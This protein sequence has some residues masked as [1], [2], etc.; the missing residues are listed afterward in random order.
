M[1]VVHLSHTDGG[2][3]AGRAAYRIHTSL[4][5]KG[6][7]SALLVSEKRTLDPTV[8]CVSKTAPGR[9]F[10]HVFEY[11]EARVARRL[12]RDSSVF[13]SPAR[14]AH[15]NPTR[16]REVRQ[17]DIVAT[18]WTNG[19]FMRP[20]GLAGLRQPIVWRLSDTW[21]FTGGC[22]YPGHCKGFEEHCGGCPQLASPG[23]TDCSASLVRRKISA[24]KDIDLTIVAPSRWMAKLARA[25][26][27]FSG[28]RIEV[29]PTGVDLSLYCPGD[30]EAARKRWNIPQDRLVILFGA[31]SPLDDKRKGYG[32][33]L[34]A[35]KI[36]ACK[37]QGKRI[38]AV[39]FGSDS[40]LPSGLP[41]DAISI[42]RLHDDQSLI[43]A[44]NSADLVVVPSLED[45]LPN[46]GLEAIACGT[47]VAAF[48]VCGMPDI[49]CD[50]WNGCL[51]PAD[52]AG[53]LGE[54]IAKVLDDPQG[55]LE[56]RSNARQHAE[57]RFSLEEQAG[58]YIRLYEDLILQQR[59]RRSESM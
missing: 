48:D 19:A 34:D 9:F 47:P 39:I 55:L 27:L 16:S 1:K 15:F 49:V 53:E 36:I 10:A 42:G 59:K 45:N 35:L 22:H 40:P 29:I 56:M 28:R 8:K 26:T 37:P 32:E 2:A 30:R 43:D 21:P 23:E 13:L 33:L 41:I 11:M 14:Y 57:E 6:V 52:Q 4:R 44:Y 3:G 54:M 50:G 38:M 24:W 25:S 31:V 51:V 7:E 58:A 5:D 18:Y 17:A 12:A 20:E 46:V